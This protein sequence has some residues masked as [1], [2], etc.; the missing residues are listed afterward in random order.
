MNIDLLKGIALF[1]IL[2]LV[3]VVFL[4]HIHLF[5]FATPLLYMY[6]AIVFRRNYPRCAMLLWSFAMGLAVDVFSNTPGMAAASMTLLGFVQPYILLP[7][8]NRDTPAD[9]EP[10]LRQMGPAKFLW[11]AAICVFFYCLVFFTIED[12]SFFNPL[13]W[14]GSIVGSSLLTL[15]FV[16]V[17]ENFRSK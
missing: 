17:I 16:L 14:L 10:T 6:V 3:Q 9:F 4:N 2:L 1:V 11:Y 8:T 15:I 7:F 12:F 13:Y 5:G